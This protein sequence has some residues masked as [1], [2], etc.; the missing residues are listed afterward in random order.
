MT[1]SKREL[2]RHFEI[3]SA[4]LSRLSPVART[5]G[6]DFGIACDE[7]REKDYLSELE[8]VMLTISAL[9]CLGYGKRHAQDERINRLLLSLMT[10]DRK[11]DRRFTEE[12]QQV[13]NRRH[14]RT[15]QNINTG[16]PF[17]CRGKNNAAP[18]AETSRRRRRGLAPAPV[19]TP[20]Q[21]D[22]KRV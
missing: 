4:P 9:Q 1:N 16:K 11:I 17:S 7:R 10:G 21:E 22:E 13:V 2:T 6:A 8:Q 5:C 12:L 18:E 19:R 20:Q 15:A 14:I 3:K